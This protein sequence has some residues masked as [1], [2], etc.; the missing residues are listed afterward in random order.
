MSHKALLNNRE[1]YTFLQADIN[2]DLSA[3]RYQLASAIRALSNP[4]WISKSTFEEHNLVEVITKKQAL[5]PQEAL[6]RASL[7]TAFDAIIEAPQKFSDSALVRQASAFDGPPAT[8]VE[9][10]APYVRCIVAS[11]VRLEQQRHELSKQLSRG[12]LSGR[13]RTTRASRAA[14]EGGNKATTRKER[15]FPRKMNFS[16]VLST[17]QTTWLEALG[18]LIERESDTGGE[19]SRSS[20]ELLLGGSPESVVV[21]D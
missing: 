20:T 9:D 12:G 16:Q 19:L 5:V 11:D 13:S 3:L 21:H 10:L 6:V 4:G 2:T 17:G 15:H 18:S 1:G 14:L 8:I 7:Y